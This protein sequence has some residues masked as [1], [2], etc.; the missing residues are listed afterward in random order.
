MHS[1][2]YGVSINMSEVWEQR[3]QL[4]TLGAFALVLACAGLA[5]SAYVVHVALPFNPIRL[6]FERWVYVTFWAPEG[7]GF[8]TRDPQEAALLFFKRETDGKWI[9]AYVG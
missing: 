8:F 7:W 1:H 4:Q 2:G 9:S 3:R 6:P 5:V